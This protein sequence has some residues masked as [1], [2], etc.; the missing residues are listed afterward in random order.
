MATFCSFFFFLIYCVCIT[1]VVDAVG[2][3]SK[4]IPFYVITY[5]QGILPQN[6]K[7]QKVKLQI[8]SEEKKGKNTTKR[9]DL[10]SATCAYNAQAHT[11]AKTHRQQLKYV[12][13]CSFCYIY[14]NAA[15]VF[16]SILPMLRRAL[17]RTRTCGWCIVIVPLKSLRSSN[18][19]AHVLSHFFSFLS[20]VFCSPSR[21]TLACNRLR[22][23]KLQ[24]NESIL[25]SCVPISSCAKNLSSLVLFVLHV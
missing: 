9:N 6:S 2:K 17:A 12:E 24:M 5:L 13:F 10:E 20:L 16:A 18:C 14:V 3:K 15:W 8:V 11:P 4:E 23:T 1:V 22:I 7:T 21:C 25:I 19:F